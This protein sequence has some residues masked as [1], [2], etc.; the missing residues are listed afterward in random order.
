MC[1]STM[2]QNGRDPTKEGVPVKENNVAGSGQKVSSKSMTTESEPAAATVGKKTQPATTT[3]ASRSAES[4]ATT[5]SPPESPTSAP[6]H[7]SS[8]DG[9][10][11]TPEVKGGARDVEMKPEDDEE[12]RVE[13]ADHLSLNE[14][15]VSELEDYC[16]RILHRATVKSN[17]SDVRNLA[18]VTGLQLYQDHQR[19]LMDFDDEWKRWVS[20]STGVISNE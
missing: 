11:S 6:N 2:N 1:L 16:A 10:M 18:R 17:T 20:L 13:R 15:L 8:E 12:D 7:T 19:A 5:A 9:F 4:V 3:P 14:F